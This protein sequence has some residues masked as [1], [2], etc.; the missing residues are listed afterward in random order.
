MNVG[1]TVL[2]IYSIIPVIRIITFNIDFSV[3]KFRKIQINK[4]GLFAPQIY[5]LF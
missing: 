2:Y 4:F 3:N 1:N 5:F